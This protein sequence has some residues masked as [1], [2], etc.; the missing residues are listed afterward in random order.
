[1]PTELRGLHPDNPV[2]RV[3][4]SGIQVE[5]PPR[6]RG[7]GPHWADTEARRNG[8]RQPHTV[9]LI[10]ALAGT[11]RRV[12]GSLAS[13]RMDLRI[14][15][16]PQQGGSYDQ[17]LAVAQRAE[18]TGFDAFFRSDHYLKMG[19][20]SGLPGPTD[21]WITLGAIARE[22]TT[23]RLGT[24]VCSATFRLPGPLAVAVAQV[25]EMSGG[26]VELGIGAGWYDD[27][28][29][30]YGI[31][32]PTLGERFDRLEEQLE[33]ITGLW[34]TPAD[35]QYSFEGNHYTLVG[36]PALPKP[37]QPGGPPI[38][39]GGWGAK[40]TPSLAARFAHEFN[41]P[42]APVGGL[43]RPGGQGAGRVRGHRPRSRRARLLGGAGPVLRRERRRARASGR[44]D[45]SGPRRRPPPERRR[46]IAGR[47]A[48]DPGHLR[49]GRRAARLPPGARPPRPRPD[50]RWSASASSP[51]SPDP[52]SRNL[53]IC[54]RRYDGFRCPVSEDEPR[55][56]PRR[57][58]GRGVAAC[59]RT[60]GSWRRAGA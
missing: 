15:V 28:H 48:R 7:L 39:V 25:D 18:S 31:P 20:V 56:S 33:I 44:L 10:D 47:G 40:R 29:V 22:T 43:R 51:S 14:F 2:N 17:L 54:A 45:R 21:T 50:L 19:D 13:A 35:S 41:L 4:E 16:E 58:G 36:S 1:M 9:A 5:L 57:G 27:E 8:D 59:A 23:I 26:R 37:V 24:L 42:F 38:I 53:G 46:R 52:P 6:V 55:V 30:A 11:A 60:D 32:F 34:R 49:R 3:S 12:G